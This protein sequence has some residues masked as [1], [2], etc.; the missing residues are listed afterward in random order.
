M[1]RDLLAAY[2]GWALVTGASSGI[3]EAYADAL[4]ARG[5][6]LLLVARRAEKLEDVAA[7]ARTTGVEAVVVA[8]DL[9]QPGAVDRIAEAAGDR[10]IGLVVANAGF[11]WSGRFAEAQETEYVR[12]VQLNCTH[13]V[14]LVRR[15]LPPMLRRGRGGVI[16]VS[17]VAGFQPTPWFTVYGATKAFD[18]AL[19]EG[20][21]HELRGT[22]VE[23]QALCPGATRTEFAVRA[24]PGR[25][26]EGADPRGVVESSLRRLGGGPSAVTG[27]GNRVTAML[28]RFLP[29]GVT[30]HCTGSVLARFL[31]RTSPEELR[32]RPWN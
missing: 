32:R 9:T 16:V 18:L 20:L 21:W 25:P 30:A 6:P 10:E 5:F 29:R 11:G 7:R 4:A 3:G 26:P 12:M 28:H 23:V 17:S 24:H 2:G 14:A 1:A 19:A 15:F 22:G 13:V 27:F 8:A 31:L